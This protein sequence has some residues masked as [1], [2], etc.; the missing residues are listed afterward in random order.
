MKS[1]HPLNW[2]VAAVTIGLGLTVL[3]PSNSCGQVADPFSDPFASETDMPR[4][5]FEF[6]GGSLEELFGVLEALEQ[7]PPETNLLFTDDAA[8]VEVQEL[9]LQNVTFAALLEIVTTVVSADQG[10]EIDIRQISGGQNFLIQLTGDTAEPRELEY[11]V[12]QQLLEGL[13]MEDLVAVIERAFDVAGESTPPQFHFHEE[14]GLLMAALTYRE[15]EIAEDLFTALA[16]APG[17]E[18]MKRSRQS[19]LITDEL[20]GLREK[21]E[22]QSAL[23]DKMRDENPSE[24]TADPFALGPAS[25][26]GNSARIRLLQMELELMERQIISYMEQLAQLRAEELGVQ[27]QPTEPEPVKQ[28]KSQP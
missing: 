27:F 24:L 16:E 14:T 28:L 18:E 12:S 3:I 4:F 17:G 25:K 7:I 13:R 21:F 26:S 11:F 15:K 6:P 2:S 19:A 20:S 23:L 1:F 9:I 22:E 8:K 5:N 10:K